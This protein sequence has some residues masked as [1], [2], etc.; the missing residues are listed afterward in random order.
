MNDK[1]NYVNKFGVSFKYPNEW[2]KVKINNSFF[3]AKNTVNET[4]LYLFIYKMNQSNYSKTKNK[5]YKLCKKPVYSRYAI[6]NLKDVKQ[7]TETINHHTFD[8]YIYAY[9][10]RVFKNKVKRLVSFNENGFT[11]F[12]EFDTLSDKAVIENKKFEII[13]KSFN[14]DTSKLNTLPEKYLKTIQT[15]SFKLINSFYLGISLLV[16]L[17]IVFGIIYNKASL[18]Y[19]ISLVILIPLL[20]LIFSILLEKE[21]TSNH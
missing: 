17:I 9:Q 11:F 13:L 15:S 19:I 3:S 8:N 5:L 1:T 10:P 12:F 18:L 20:H 16:F 21:N 4:D 7:V 14:V 2:E 6:A